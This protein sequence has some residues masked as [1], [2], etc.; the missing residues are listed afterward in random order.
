M[1]FTVEMRLPVPEGGEA[2][3]PVTL[4]FS[5][6]PPETLPFGTPTERSTA[7]VYELLATAAFDGLS[8]ELSRA[9]FGG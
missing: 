1:D 8:A 2:P 5:V 7:E 6:A 3:A 9:F 4:R